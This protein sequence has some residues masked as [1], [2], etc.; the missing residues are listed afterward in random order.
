MSHEDPTTI[1]T[2]KV[3]DANSQ[4]TTWTSHHQPTRSVYKLLTHA[5][6][7]ALRPAFKTPSLR[8]FVDLGSL[9]LSFLVGPHPRHLAANRCT[10]LH[11]SP[12]V[13]RLT[14]LPAAELTQVWL[15]NSTQH[16]AKWAGWRGEGQTGFS[17][18]RRV[19]ISCDLSSELPS[20]Y[21]A[22]A[23]PLLQCEIQNPVTSNPRLGK[24]H[25]STVLFH[26]SRWTRPS[27]SV[28]SAGT[29]GRHVP[30]WAH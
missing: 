26:V 29:T 6:T 15:G 13:S 8:A 23:S 14:F 4:N 12:A 7:L 19:P 5:E 22:T 17:T 27:P 18:W 21:P 11:H 10:L 28:S 30:L 20:R 25:Q 24:E 16:R 9:S 1:G 2:K 3:H